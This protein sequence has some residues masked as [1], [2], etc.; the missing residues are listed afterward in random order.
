[1][2][3]EFDPAKA[4]ADL[5]KH[6]VSLADAA[7]VFADP[8][9]LTMEDPDSINEQRFITIGLGGTGEL[10]VVIYTERDAADRLIS[11]RPATRKERKHYES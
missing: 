1:M 3:I 11:A 2:R 6:H 10:L 8:L 4:K 9:A 7:G 5:L